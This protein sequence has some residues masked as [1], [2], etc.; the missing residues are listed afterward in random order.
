MI[1]HLPSAKAVACWAQAGAVVA[2]WALAAAPPTLAAKGASCV[3][4]GSAP[5]TTL[6]LPSATAGRHY[7]RLL[8]QGGTPPYAI[9][10]DSGNLAATGLAL[11]AS[12]RLSGVPQNPGDWSFSVSVDDARA[13]GP[14][15]QAYALR[16]VRPRVSTE[17]VDAATQG[18]MAHDRVHFPAER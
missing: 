2:V 7:S 18:I 6:R 9:T 5:G 15:R 11:D 16:V 10:I 13:C 14:V 1:I 4:T 3:Q 8:V 17:R 12:G